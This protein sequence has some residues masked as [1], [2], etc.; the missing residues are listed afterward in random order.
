MENNLSNGRERRSCVRVEYP[1]GT[2]PRLVIGEYEYEVM[3]ISE[4]G[5]K[6]ITDHPERF[7]PGLKEVEADIIFREGKNYEIQGAILRIERTQFSSETRIA[8]FLYDGW[9][10][11]SS[12]IDMEMEAQA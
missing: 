2:G 10:I 6:F 3:D 5:V 8:I 12:R 11:P 9:G 1:V 7:C 4:K